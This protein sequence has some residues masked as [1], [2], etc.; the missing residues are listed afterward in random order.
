MAAV[1]PAAASAARPGSNQ[2]ACDAC[3]ETISARAEIC[4]KCGVRQ[5]RAVSK[6]A[7]ILLTFFLGGVGGHKFYLGKYWQGILYLLF[8]WTLIPGFV[9]LIELIIYAA[10]SE[11]R[12]NEKYSAAGGAAGIVIAVAVGGFFMIFILGIMAAV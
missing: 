1:N 3:G 12:L 4:P 2:K 9:A 11:E 8:F 7:L 5:R 10:T 6:V